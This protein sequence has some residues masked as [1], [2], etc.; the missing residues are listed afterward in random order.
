LIRI[1]HFTDIHF[2]ADPSQIAWRD[3]LSKRVLGWMNLA[4]FRRHHSFGDAAAIVAA[5]VQDLQE[6]KPDH[7]VSTGD[8]TGLS[9]R[10]EFAA[11][12][13]ALAP[14]LD[15]EN[16][17]GIPGNHDVYVRS[18]VREQL[19][20]SS[21][22]QWSRT[23]LTPDEFP[24]PLR[25]SY[26]YPL[27]RLLNENVALLC[28]RDVHPNPL[29]DSSGRVGELQLELLELLLKDPRIALRTK[30]VALHCGI[31][32]AG[33]ALDR[34]FHRLRDGR[35]LLSI[36]AA[37]KVS[38]LI[39]G[40]THAPFVLTGRGPAAL[41]FA[42]PGSLTSSRHSQA[43]HI[44][45]IESGTIEVAARRYHAIARKFVPWHDAPQAGRV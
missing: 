19:Y 38:L 13:S 11:A 18:A 6:L 41:A 35:R 28:L 32:R 34:R 1:A 39:H 27:V 20:E 30:I 24:E 33:G 45:R 44:Y 10:S 21:F 22:G 25:A 12:R 16:I 37:G 26:P 40:H 5:L 23:D 29:H 15:L 14:I 4:L 9:L 2:T 7:I 8:L 17:T 31:H 3:L 43:Y 42:N 36:A